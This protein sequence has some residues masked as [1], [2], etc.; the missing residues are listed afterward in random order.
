MPRPPTPLVDGWEDKSDTT[1]L[2]DIVSRQ[3]RRRLQAIELIWDWDGLETRTRMA[4]LLCISR[5]QLCRWVRAFNEGGIDGL[6]F[7]QR[8]PPGRKHKMKGFDFDGEMRGRPLD[9]PADVPAPEILIVA[10]LR[11]V[12][13]DEKVITVGY[14]TLAHY[15]RVK[16]IVLRQ[17]KPDPRAQFPWRFSNHAAPAGDLH[18]GEH[19]SDASAVSND[20]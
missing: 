10:E 4:E 9:W 7:P 1:R 18:P 2:W 12:L 11:R 15:L 3:R 13:R 8:Q 17:R 5:R 20:Y 14:G 6:M 16:G 19:Q